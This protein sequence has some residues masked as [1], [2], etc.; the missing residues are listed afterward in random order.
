MT[1]STYTEHAVVVTP[2]DEDFK[3]LGFGAEI[4]RGSRR[5]L[6]NRDGTFN[7]V[8]EGLGPVSSLSLYHWSLTISWPAFLGAI[9]VLYVALNALFAVAFLLCGPTALHSAPGLPESSAFARAFF[10]SVQSFATIG[11]GHVVPVGLAA[12]LL[13]TLEALI[14]IVGVALATGLVFARFSRPLAKI[15]Y[16]DRAVIAPYRNGTALEFRIANQRSSQIIELEA[17]VILSKIENIAGVTARKFYELRLER[18]RV[19]FFAL[20]WTIVHPVD[21]TSPLFGASEADLLEAD[22]EILILLTGTDET[23][24]QVV[25]SRSSYKADEI[26]W[27]AKFSNIFM[28]TRE[29]GVMGMDLSRIHELESHGPVR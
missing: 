16:S 11:Y 7:V 3:D 17:K 18:S 20:S 8:R 9:A 1:S 24:S 6:L 10:F 15:I 29:G 5:R 2:T 22:A 4:A 27:N 13:V 21:R 26:V 23:S 19:T 25:H 12:N 14:N 28:R